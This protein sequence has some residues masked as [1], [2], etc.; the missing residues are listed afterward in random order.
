MKSVPPGFS[1][2]QSLQENSTQ[3]GE[4]PLGVLEPGSGSLAAACHAAASRKL[5]KLCRKQR[6][7]L[8]AVAHI[9]RAL[10]L[11]KAHGD[12][13]GVMAD[14]EFLGGLYLA[15]GRMDLAE[16]ALNCALELV[17][18]LHPDAASATAYGN[19][20]LICKRRGRLNHAKKMF[21]K[22]L[23]IAQQLER[24]DLISVQYAN[25][26]VLFAEAGQKVRAEILLNNAVRL[27]RNLKMQDA[28]DQ[29]EL[30]LRSLH[31]H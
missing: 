24:S 13:A 20:G 4:S 18:A 19:M 15:S 27:F 21:L 9:E 6:N 26:A 31:A 29:A 12:R 23:K 25:L 17:P 16:H 10:E 22:S 30:M 2:Q 11:D 5:A 3:G 1:A 14:Y 7:L 8:D 28:L